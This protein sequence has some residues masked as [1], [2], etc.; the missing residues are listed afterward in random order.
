MKNL[1]QQDIKIIKLSWYIWLFW[2]I[3][4]WL[5]EFL[6]HFS[7]N[8]LNTESLYGFFT[9]VPMNNLF[10]GHFLWILWIP[11]YFIG[12]FHLYK[13]LNRVE[14]KL[15]K[16]YFMFGI[17]SFIVW[18]IWLSSRWF[19]W[20]IVHYKE[21]IN[22]QTYDLIISNYSF[23]LESMVQFLRVFIFIVSLLWV[24]IILTS[25]TY[26]PKW[27]SIF[28]PFTLLIIIFM[29]IFIPTIGKYLVPISMN[30]VHFIIFSLSLFSLFIFTKKWE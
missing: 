8:V 4:T 10:I 23:L 5:W 21:A 12:Y 15:S 17:L 14:N 9:Y 27:M 29:T 25:K 2:S 20:T 18:W 3:I 16:L 11:L 30:V 22:P 1:T 28:N 6:L 13:M 24:Y 7:T 26:Y 19:L